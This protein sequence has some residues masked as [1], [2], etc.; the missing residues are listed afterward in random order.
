MVTAA[1]RRSRALLEEN[2]HAALMPDAPTTQL[3]SA[4]SVLVRTLAMDMIASGQVPTT[5]QSPF[6]TLLLTFPR[7]LSRSAFMRVEKT[8]DVINV[9]YVF[10]CLLYT[11][12]SPRDS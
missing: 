9:H 7:S 1:R 5:P 8:V 10:G 11:S 12:P 3:G 2:R 4:A 6:F